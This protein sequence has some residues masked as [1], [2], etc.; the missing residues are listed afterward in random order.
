ML[1]VKLGNR[2]D[3]PTSHSG[4]SLVID[5]CTVTARPKSSAHTDL[6]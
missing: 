3:D 6:A 5:V 4:N 1:R 2:K